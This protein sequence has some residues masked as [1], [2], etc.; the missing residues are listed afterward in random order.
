MIGS[1]YRMLEGKMQ[2]PIDFEN[3]MKEMLGEEY[4]AFIKS[5]DDE[6]AYGLRFNPLKIDRESFE[7]NV[8]SILDRVKWAEEGYYYDASMQP[9][10]APLHEAGAYYIQEPSAMSA[11][12]LLEVEP[13]EFVCDLCA[14]PGGKS[15]QIAGK[16][17]GEGLLVTNEFYG[18][19]AKI[20]SQNIERMGVRNA[21][22]LNEGTD[23]IADRFPE[24]FDKVMVDAPCSGEGMFRKDEV[25][26]N[27]WSLPQVLVCAERQA[28][29]LDNAAKIV[30]PGGAMVYSTCTFSIEEN[31][32]IVKEFLE[33]NKDFIIAKPSIHKKLVEAGFDEKDGMYRLW[34][35]KLKGEGHF[36]VRFVKQSI[37]EEEEIS[38]KRKPVENLAKKADLKYYE[39]FATASLMVKP[40]GQFIMFG[41]SIYLL[42]EGMISIKGLKVERAGLKLGTNKKNRFEPDHAFAL[43]L[44][45]EEVKQVV[46][47][48]S[49]DANDIE[50][51]IRGEVIECE[52]DSGWTLVAVDG[53]SIGWGKASGGSLKNHYPKGLRR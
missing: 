2:L 27:E 50:K 17:M 21:V 33:R 19:R 32:N 35:H 53:V 52:F 14:A 16:L 10:K 44:K 48:S 28:M 24:F 36:A 18:S 43:A 22:V 3:R 4:E 34:P 6:R 1:R 8:P 5:Y 42:P 9:G 15:T 13:G 31:E 30:K 47:T 12:E 49:N 40:E 25:A 26:I 29:I 37:D 39:E 45:P 41:D 51:Y 11:A 7:K 23:V 38:Y 20:L 46:N